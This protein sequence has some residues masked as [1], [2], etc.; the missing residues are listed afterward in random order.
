[1]FL[2][3]EESALISRASPSVLLTLALLLAP[4]V[5]SRDAA[6]QD[7]IRLVAVHPCVVIGEKD[8]KKAQNYEDACTAAIARTGVNHVPDEQ[9]SA[10][11]EK[12]PKKSCVSANKESL[13]CLG[14]LAANTQ[15]GHSLLVTVKLGVPTYVSGHVVDTR[16]E[17]LRKMTLRLSAPAQLLKEDAGDGADIRNRPFAIRLLRQLRILPRRSPPRTEPPPPAPPVAEAPAPAAPPVAAA[18][19]PVAVEETLVPSVRDSS[20]GRSWKTPVAY[21]AAGVGVA[22]LGLAGFLVF[23]GDKAMRDSNAYY[24]DGRYPTS[25]DVAQ[26]AALREKAASRRVLSGVSAA[27]GAALAGAGVYLWLQERQA[28]PTPGVASLS[29]GPGGVSILGVLP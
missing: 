12:E 24:A 21:T 18:P 8:K 17:E 1:M 6:A 27:V 15:S 3:S 19:A 7:D 25:K 23:D 13:E 16:G 4:T 9:V 5:H 11:L 28:T 26:I 29:V 10:F 2:Y 14:R 22:A 20:S